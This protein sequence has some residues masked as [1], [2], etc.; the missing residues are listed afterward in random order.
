MTNKHHNNYELEI[1]IL[2][3]IIV[4]LKRMLEKEKLRADLLQTE[5]DNI[6]DFYALT[7]SEIA[8]SLKRKPY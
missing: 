8:R 7:E 3:D 4:T 6:D 5:L 1:G 2:K